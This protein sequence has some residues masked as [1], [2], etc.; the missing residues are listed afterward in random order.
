ME[1]RQHENGL[2]SFRRRR[3]GGLETPLEG[4]MA[5]ENRRLI[6]APPL[7]YDI[8]VGISFFG[9]LLTLGYSFL[10]SDSFL[11]FLGTAVAL[12]GAWAAISNERMVCNLTDRTY[13]RVEGK[14]LRRRIVQGRLDELDAVV[15]T[16]EVSPFL[17]PAAQAVIYRL[18]VHW[19]GARH[20]L[21]VVGRE[22]HTLAGNSPINAA[23][24]RMA[25]IGLAYA[26][27]LG[28]KFFDNSYF[29][30]ANP[31]PIL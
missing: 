11:S 1:Q 19:K 9:G 18:L 27:H 5:R 29:H 24:S 17:L 14:G 2:P 20:P 22:S 3:K 13:R 23:A 30:G 26:N 16:A 10:E 7:W 25:S 12:S 21:L 6:F 4:R 31:V 8:L 28:V 15:L